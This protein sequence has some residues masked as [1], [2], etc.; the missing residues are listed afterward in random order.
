MTKD[1][2]NLEEMYLEIFHIGQQSP[3]Y[4]LAQQSLVQPHMGLESFD[5]R[6]FSDSY[7]PESFLGPKNNDH[8]DESTCQAGMMF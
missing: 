2:K 1:A 6:T 3:T 4:D 7:M 5:T 8:K